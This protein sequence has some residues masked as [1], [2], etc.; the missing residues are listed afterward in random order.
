LPAV[1][2]VVSAEIAP[3]VGAA[4]PAKVTLFRRRFTE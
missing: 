4:Q 3:R 1:D 2:E